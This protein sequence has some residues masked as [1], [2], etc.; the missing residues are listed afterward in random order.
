MRG[1]QSAVGCDLVRYT[2]KGE[3]AANA[4]CAWRTDTLTAECLGVSVVQEA[5]APEERSALG[6][7]VVHG[8]GRQ[9]QGV[10]MERWLSCRRGL[11]DRFG[12]GEAGE[13]R[14]AFVSSEVRPRAAVRQVC[15]P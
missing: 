7:L 6:V 4:R 11:I 12:G 1:L 10:T 3:P 9:R 13:E 14:F 2:S 8:I 5:E 15:F